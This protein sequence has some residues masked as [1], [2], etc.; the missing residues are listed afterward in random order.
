[1]GLMYF[2]NWFFF[3][4]IWLGCCFYFILATH[5]LPVVSVLSARAGLG[6]VVTVQ[7]E[8]QSLRGLPQPRAAWESPV[9]ANARLG[10]SQIL[11]VIIATLSSPYLSGQ[12]RGES[13]CCGL[14][15]ACLYHFNTPDTLASL[16]QQVHS[17]LFSFSVSCLN[18]A[19]VCFLLNNDDALTV[20]T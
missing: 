8:R 1:M 6:L 17:G 7:G 20:L 9:N 3:S 12:V 4:V 19:A 11:L 5:K 16:H 15:A 10:R 2:N 13:A 14:L 18:D